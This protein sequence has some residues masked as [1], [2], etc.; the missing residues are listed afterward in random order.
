MDPASGSFGIAC[1]STI[2]RTRIV[3]FFAMFSCSS[4]LRPR[5]TIRLWPAADLPGCSPCIFVLPGTLGAIKQSFLPSG[6]LIAEQQASA[7]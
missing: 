7:I 1:A 6:G 2:S 3:M 4:V 5:R